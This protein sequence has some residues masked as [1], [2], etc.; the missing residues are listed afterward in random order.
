M[1]KAILFVVAATIV[2]V[3]MGSHTSAQGTSSRIDGGEVGR[4]QL[5]RLSETR[6][7]MIDT[8]TGQ[9]WSWTPDGEWRNEGNPTQVQA[10]KQC[11]KSPP[12]SL[13][14]P[15][16]SV[17]MIVIQ[18][19]DRAIPGSDGSVRIRLGDI[20]EGQALLSVVT[21]DE[22]C[23][24]ERTSVSQGDSVEFSVGK[25]KYTAHLQEL[26]NILIGDDF[27]RIIVRAGAGL[28]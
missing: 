6:L 23:L 20:T 21:A 14:L 13:D 9:C 16:K 15:E 2:L 25:K 11:V 8:A 7:F 3:D 1:N 5:M 22:D 24:L 10:Q 27:A 26:R 12:P 28:E 18:R 19:E 17:E 4:Y